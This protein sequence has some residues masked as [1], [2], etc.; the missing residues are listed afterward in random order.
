[1]DEALGEDDEEEVPLEALKERIK[2]L[3]EVRDSSRG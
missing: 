2:D 3:I 1:M